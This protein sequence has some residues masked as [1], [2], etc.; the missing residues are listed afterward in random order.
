MTGRRGGTQHGAAPPPALPE[1]TVHRPALLGPAVLTGLVVA[2]TACT[3]GIPPASAPA[4]PAVPAPPPAL[5]AACM[6]DTAALGIVTGVTWTPNATTA[7]ATRCVYD[8]S[9]A[10]TAFFVTVDITALGR[11]APA[12]E[13]KNLPGFCDAGTLTPFQAGAGAFMCLFQGGN[14]FSAVV[15]NDRV[16]TISASSVP[17]GIDKEQLALTFAADLTRAAGG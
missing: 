17:A 6:L 11:N 9:G 14:V 5:P 4:P 1:A 2:L 3:G 16:V 7:N 8:P 13:L 10:P 12:D 15:T